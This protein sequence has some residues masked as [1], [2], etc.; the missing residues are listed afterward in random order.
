[1]CLAARYLL[2]HSK[3]LWFSHLLVDILL[4]QRDNNLKDKE[5][6]FDELHYRPHLKLF[7]TGIYICSLL[8][9][10]KNFKSTDTT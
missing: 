1:M 3:S 6:S 2:F 7:G 8:K 9:S 10:Y 5:Y 4:T